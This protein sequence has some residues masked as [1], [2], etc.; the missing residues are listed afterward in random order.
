MKPAL[1]ALAT[2]GFGLSIALGGA[3]LGARLVMPHWPEFASER[4]MRPVSLPDFGRVTLGN[5]GFDGWF[6]QNNGDFRIHIHINTEGLRNPESARPDGALWTIG[7]SFTFGW[8]VARE[9]SFGSVA[10]GV[11]GLPFYSIASPGTD[12]CGYMALVAR[13]PKPIRPRA[14]VLGLTIEND[15]EEY[16]DCR[17]P[18]PTVEVTSLTPLNRAV[19]KEW[20]L[21]HSAFYNLMATT[22]KRSAAMVDILQAIGVVERRQNVNWHQARHSQTVLD[23]TAAA[24]AKLQTM[25]PSGTPFIVLLIPARFDIREDHGEWAAD[26]EALVN[27]LTARGLTV[28]DPAS[29][30]RQAGADRAHFSHDGHWSAL[31]HA[32]AGAAVAS[33]LGHI[34]TQD[35]PP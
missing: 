19:V 7:D 23:G 33:A 5:P 2:L 3:E 10:A 25:L 31:G 29:A 20:L 26:R 27:A 32:I 18:D 14:V 28:A 12:I 35:V 4:F 34:L 17:R 16:P 8:G 30:L 24:V 11:L 6:A 9:E 21:A 1:S 22:L 15:L 13:Q